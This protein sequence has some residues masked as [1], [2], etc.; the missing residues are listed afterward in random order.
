VSAARDVIHF[1]ET[2]P[3][4][5]AQIMARLRAVAADLDGVSEDLLKHH[6]QDHFGG[7]EAVDQLAEAA[8]IGRG[9]RVLD[10]CSGLGGPAR[11]LAQRFGCRVSALDLTRS[12]HDGAVRLTR[13]VGL[14][15]LVDFHHGDALDMPFEDAAFDVVMSQEA[16]CHVP[17]KARLTG[18][19]ARV[20]K[21]GGRVAF[22]DILRTSEL[23]PAVEQ[24]LHDEM[25]FNELASA[26]DYRTLLEER[27]LEV[28]RIDDLGPLW[29][30]ILRDRLA[31]YRSLEDTT[32]ER[33]GRP[34]FERWDRT[35][36]FFVGLFSAGELTGGRIVAGRRQP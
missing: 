12:R 1:Y 29:T 27:G 22:T 7:L 9:S 14:D 35:Y 10:V 16:F 25:T 28:I 32:T 18:E 31:M 36:A 30:R 23:T 6:D 19:C 34:H 26:D 24:R 33:F 20:L 11:H 15:H 5:E 2:H 13:M 4:N 3:I 8:G 21:P 17:G